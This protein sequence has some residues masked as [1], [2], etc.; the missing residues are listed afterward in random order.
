MSV[1]GPRAQSRSTTLLVVAAVHGVVLW[2]LWR[3]RV[4]VN[5]EV[6]TFASVLFFVPPASSHRTAAASTPPASGPNRPK[7]AIPAPVPQPADSGTAITLPATPAA[8]IDWSGQLEAAARAELEQEDKARKQLRALTR[9]FEVDPD[10]RDARHASATS[11]ATATCLTARQRRTVI[12]LR[13]QGRTRCP[14]CHAPASPQQ[15]VATLLDEGAHLLRI[16]MDL[17]VVARD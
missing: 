11:K 1:F 10:P 3:V 5:R 4:P 15:L 9:R 2:A 6:E 7:Q 13:R 12:G 17:R 14:E 16:L 8:R